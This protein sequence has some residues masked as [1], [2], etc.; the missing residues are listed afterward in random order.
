MTTWCPTARIARMQ[1]PPGGRYRGLSRATLLRWPPSNLNGGA[2]YSVDFGSLLAG[3]E[4]V[5]TCVFGTAAIASQAW[6]SIFGNTATAW[7][8][9]TASGVQSIPVC[10]LTSLGNV[11]QVDVT[12]CISAEAALITPIPPAVS[13]NVVSG[14]SMAA[15]LS[16]L[17]TTTPTNGGW[18]NNAGIPAFA[19]TVTAPTGSTTP[20]TLAT[21]I[22]MQ[23]WLATLPTSP[24][25]SGGWWNNDG[26]PAQADASTAA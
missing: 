21:Q 10:V 13:G 3:G 4:Y 25:S 23:A 9:W 24:P 1:E 26:V 12:I 11:Y 17:P 22:Q 19:G 7:L 5:V 14:V 15:W 20:D 2:D 16:S 8:T 18:W 6:T